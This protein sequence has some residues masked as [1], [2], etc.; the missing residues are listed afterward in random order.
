MS[1]ATGSTLAVFGEADG[2][3]G[4]DERREGRVERHLVYASGRLSGAA[5]IRHDYPV[6]PGDVVVDGRGIDGLGLNSDE[7]VPGPPILPRKAIGLRGE[8][9]H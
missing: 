1:M 2:G 9:V 7:Q 5:E 3:R 4:V 8:D 6:R